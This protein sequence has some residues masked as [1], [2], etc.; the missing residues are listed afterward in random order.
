MQ[1]M[2]H[3]PELIS[4]LALILACAGVVTIFFRKIK[5]P[6]VLG[7]IIAGLLVGPHVSW[8]PT[9][10]DTENIKVWAEIGVI[11]LLFALGLEFSFKKLARVGG[12]A[13][14]T[15]VIEVIG[16]V[17]LGFITG[18]LFGW[19][20]MDSL[21]LG[22]ILAISSTTIII[23]AFEELGVKSRGFVS[24]VFGVLI[25]EDLVA[26]LLMVLLSTVAISNQFAGLEA[27]YSV[28]KLL[29]FLTIWFLAGIFLLPTLLRKTKQLVNEETLLIVSV[30]LCFIMVVLATKAGFSPALGAFIMGS[31]LAET[32]EAEKIEHLVKPLKDLFGAIFFISVGMLIDPKLLIEHAVPVAVITLVTI[33]GKLGSTMIGALLSGQSLRHSVQ[34]GC[35]LAQIGE[36]SFIIASLGLSLKVTSEFLYPVAVGVSVI[37]TF[38]T[39]YLI[40]SADGV[41][42]FLEKHL[43]QNWQ[44]GLARYSA[45]TR[46]VSTTTEWSSVVRGYAVRIGVNAVVIVSLFLGLERLLPDW[47]GLSLGIAL[48]CSAPFFWALAV[49]RTSRKEISNLWANRRYRA[50]II[51]FEVARVGVAIG[52]FAL[53]APSF[54]NLNVAFGI[55]FGLAVVLLLLFSQYWNSAYSWFESRFIE[56]FS[57]RDRLETTEPPPPA[58][59]PWDA[60]IAR[61]DVPSDSALVGQTLEEL[62][63]RE[64]FGITIALIE[65]GR[66]TLAA[67]TRYERIYPNDRINVIGT[68]EQIGRFKAA[69]MPDIAMSDQ[70]AKRVDEYGLMHIRVGESSP[71]SSKTIRESGVRE[72]TD[73]LVVGIERDGQRILNPDSTMEIRPG[74]ELWI[75]GRRERIRELVAAHG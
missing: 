23:R 41:Y 16:M 37:T 40:R 46:S 6:V 38:A 11:F 3:I 24:I 31:I 60:H 9:I 58:L 45:S 35:S 22:G 5:Q 53:L 42:G 74:D 75:V 15:A 43:P 7:Y 33:F 66:R 19:S 71:F 32:T 25:V 44:E 63:V 52:L 50:A 61:V 28:V 4:D 69:L 72:R 17:S 12:S 68:D 49:S 34:A 27:A 55:A 64:R 48:L 29:F 1:S 54:I 56:N 13:S 59:A 21:F 47:G 39:P 10:G 57:E 65:R 2:L 20:N 62:K 18:R 14:I 70:Q 8:M 26:I 73:G 30:G 36:F 51:A 67:P